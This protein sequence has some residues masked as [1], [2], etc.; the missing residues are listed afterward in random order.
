M[1]KDVGMKTAKK[2]VASPEP[3][4]LSKKIGTGQREAKEKK[5][6]E[7]IVKRVLTVFLL[8][9]VHCAAWNKT[10]RGTVIG[11]AGKGKRLNHFYHLKECIWI[12]Y[13]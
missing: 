7:M 10:T 11:R 1:R 6:D 3:I 12:F 9:V 2:Q 5:N 13:G 4:V 8:A